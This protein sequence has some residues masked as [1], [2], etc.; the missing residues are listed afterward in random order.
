MLI[1]GIETATHAVG[2]GLADEEGVIAHI[3]VLRGRRHAETLVPA[4]EAL[5]AQTEHVH[6]DIS[7]VA[8]DV[9][10]GLFTGLRV[11]VAAAK[12]F[13]LA[14]GVAVIPATSLEILAHDVAMGGLWEGRVAAIVDARRQEV[15]AQLFDV[16][17]AGAVAAGD[18]WVGPPASFA[19]RIR[20]G[21]MP[22]L[23]IGDG[24]ARHLEAFGSVPGLQCLA[25]ASPAVSSLLALAAQRSAV[26]ADDVELVYLR[27]PDAE[28]N[29]VKR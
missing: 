15:Y 12:A 24:A 20:R 21:G 25:P 2:V 16:S 6:A 11:G 9:G 19:A 4:I 7:A 27:A 22:V 18:A 28:I 13:A 3:E 17:P 5:L 8:V 23:A 29:W 14:L 1:L 10:P 26:P